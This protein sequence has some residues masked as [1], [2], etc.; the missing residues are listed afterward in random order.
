MPGPAIDRLIGNCPEE[1]PTRH[2]RCDRTT[3]LFNLEEG[4]RP[5]ASVVAF[6]DAAALDESSVLREIPLIT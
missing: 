1:D 5:A 2:S 3:R 6:R 4:G